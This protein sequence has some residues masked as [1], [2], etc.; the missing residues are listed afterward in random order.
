VLDRLVISNFFVYYAHGTE[1]IYWFNI[2]GINAFVSS[3]L[4]SKNYHTA[5]R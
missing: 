5:C 2:G 1:E 4:W 3:G